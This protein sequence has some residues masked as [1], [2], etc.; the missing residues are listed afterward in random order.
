MILASSSISTTQFSVQGL[1]P[2]PKM[3]VVLILLPIFDIFHFFRHF[4]NL[5]KFISHL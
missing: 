4:P 5:F 2:A 3:W 1:R